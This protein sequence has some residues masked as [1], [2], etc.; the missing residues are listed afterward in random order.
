MFTMGSMPVSSSHVCFDHQA[1]N[2]CVRMVATGNHLALGG[3]GDAFQ[4]A[5]TARQN[6]KTTAG[7]T[8]S[9]GEQHVQVED[10]FIPELF[11]YARSIDCAGCRVMSPR[12]MPIASEDD[13][14]AACGSAAKKIMMG[15]T[16]ILPKAALNGM[17]TFAKSSANA[18]R[19][20][21]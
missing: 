5:V 8:A 19:L 11:Q 1:I 6:R 7:N 18:Q 17:A 16:V 21:S 10:K 13:L 12:A 3:G 20:L 15:L 9:T 4:A 2:L 14:K